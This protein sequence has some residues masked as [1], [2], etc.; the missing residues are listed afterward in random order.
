MTFKKVT[1][2]LFFKLL[3]LNFLVN[4][5]TIMFYMITSSFVLM[6]QFLSAFMFFYIRLL[7][8][9]GVKNLDRDLL[10]NLGNDRDLNYIYQ[11]ADISFNVFFFKTAGVE[12]TIKRN[13]RTR[14]NWATCGSEFSK[15]IRSHLKYV[16]CDVDVN[17]IK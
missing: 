1:Q 15:D 6:N 8:D 7:L 4:I 9:V 14:R 12:I 3:P 16:V 5:K 2:V 11:T 10:V 13:S 17:I